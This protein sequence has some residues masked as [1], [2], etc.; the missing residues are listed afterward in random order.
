M[1]DKIVLVTKKTQLEELLE[2]FNT[3]E[4]AK[5][6]IEHSGSSFVD[7]EYSHHAYHKSLSLLKKCLLLEV[8]HQIVE[9]TFLSNFLFGEKDLVITLGPDGLVVNTARFLNNQPILAVNP[10][11]SRIDGILLPFE[12]ET[13][14]RKL[15]GILK[16]GFDLS[17]ITMV[18]AKLNDGQTIYGVNDL[19]IGAKSH[20]SA[21]YLIKSGDLIENHSSSGIIVS[22]GIGSTGWFRS[23][24]TGA[25]GICKSLHSPPTIVCS[26]VSDTN[27]ADFRFD[28]NADY[29]YFAV[30]EPFPSRIT[31]TNLIFGRVTK[32]RPLQI[33]SCMPDGGI[34]FSDGIENDNLEFNSGRIASINVADKKTRLIKS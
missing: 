22:T 31:K 5:F 12:P 24:V 32:D 27:P 15:L 25:R 11:R 6:Y 21:R 26:D 29:L 23:I 30:R 28:W 14:S 10:D 4:Q 13:V 9:R 7:Y 2:R 16:G 34:I 33:T 20:V 3:K 1:F 17:E 18:K 8:K 19:F